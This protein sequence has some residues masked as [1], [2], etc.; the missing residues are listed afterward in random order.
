M[1]FTKILYIYLVLC[2]IPSFHLLA[3]TPQNDQDEVRSL[4]LDQMSQE[5]CWERFNAS[6]DVGDNSGTALD[7]SS[8]VV[9]GV[10]DK[11]QIASIRFAKPWLSGKLSATVSAAVDK[12]TGNA[13]FLGLSEGLGAEQ[14][15]VEYNY[16]SWP[17]FPL[18]SLALEKEKAAYK[19]GQ[20][21]DQ[22]K[23]FQVTYCVAAQQLAREARD[24]GEFASWN[25]ANHQAVLEKLEGAD[26]PTFPEIDSYFSATV[27]GGPA[28]TNR[29]EDQEKS[30]AKVQAIIRQFENEESLCSLL[31]PL[32][33]EGS[34]HEQLNLPES[35]FKSRALVWGINGTVGRKDF[36]FLDRDQLMTDGTVGKTSSEKLPASIGARF[37]WLFLSESIEREPV[38]SLTLS[39]NRERTYDAAD[40]LTFC[41]PVDG[42]ESIDGLQSCS[43]IPGAAPAESESD[44][45]VVEYRQKYTKLGLA[46][47]GFYRGNDSKK[48]DFGF[49]VPIYFLGDEKGALQGGLA[50][51]WRD[52]GEDN[53]TLAIFVG[54]KFDL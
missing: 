19:G 15:K 10:D 54:K 4:C 5:A 2:L 34:L 29:T 25:V 51:G 8:R 12:D 9:V 1:K 43:E 40:D 30:D 14:L 36:S 37:G 47:R 38:A 44:L 17:E 31:E 49:E 41:E 11:S 7:N 6:L 23:R 33:P 24:A 26:L 42:L 45:L 22:R 13:E 39:Y 3:Q 18:F 35:V 46:I 21:L 28:N 27:S 52:Q 32:F 48:D 16:I 53:V 20:L 50:F